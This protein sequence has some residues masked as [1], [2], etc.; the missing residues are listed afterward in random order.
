[1]KISIITVC[2]NRVFTIERAICSVLNQDYSDIEYIVIDGNSTDGTKAII[3]KYADR[4]TH[5]ISE[6]DGGMYEAINKGIALSTG[7]IIGLMHSDDEFYDG[8]VLTKV[9]D[10]FLSDHNIQGVYGD[11]MYISND[12]DEKLI[13]NRI[14]GDFSELKIMQGWLPLHPTV[15]LRKDVMDQIGNYNIQYKIASDT[16]FLL[17][18]LYKFKIK[19]SYIPSYFVK[20]RVGGLSTSKSRAF[21]VFKEDYLIYK[22]FGFKALKTVIQKKMYA[23]NQYI[24]T[25]KVLQ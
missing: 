25:K 5:Y 11:G 16:D 22:S 12:N 9:V 23:L 24:T 1:M 17:R 15:Y 3:E 10:R 13:R 21:L 20:M 8:K 2:Y 19:I 18:Y 4:I 14:C 6:K 7:K